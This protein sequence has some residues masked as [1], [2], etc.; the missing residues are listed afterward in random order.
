MH[1]WQMLSLSLQLLGT[2]S[3]SRATRAGEQKMAVYM[4][5]QHTL[6]RGAY[7]DADV[8]SLCNQ[9]LARHQQQYGLHSCMAANDIAALQAPDC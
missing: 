2:D 9:Y 7:L 8:T 3:S 1:S 5:A 4:Y 6:F